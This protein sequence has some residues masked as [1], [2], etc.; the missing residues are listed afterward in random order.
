MNPESAVDVTNRI[1]MEN[2]DLFENGGVPLDSGPIDRERWT[3]SLEAR[4]AER[5]AYSAQRRELRMNL[6][7]IWKETGGIQPVNGMKIGP[8][9]MALLAYLESRE[10]DED[11]GLRGDTNWEFCSFWGR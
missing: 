11:G 5:E 6:D 4:R 9:T 1:T 8:E 2:L 3:F 7:K 10:W